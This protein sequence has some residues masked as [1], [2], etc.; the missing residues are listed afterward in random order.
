MEFR[1]DKILEHIHN[2]TPEAYRFIDEWLD[3]SPYIT[4]HTSGSTGKPKAIRLFKADMVTSAI[5]T[6][7]FFNITD[8]SSM[9]CPLSANY[10]A[11]KMMIVRAMLS[12]AN[13]WIEKPG[14]TPV[15]QDYGN[16]DL[17]AVVPSQVQ[18]LLN[19]PDIFKRL[20]H[21]LIGGAAVPREL[22]NRITAL[23]VNAYVSYGMTET[24]SHVAL[25]RIGKSSDEIYEAMS[26]ICFSTD[27]RGCLIVKSEKR[28]FHSLT[29]ND[30][31][32]LIDDKHF[33]WVGRFDNVI[34]SGGIKV[35]PE[36]IEK[37][38]QCLIPEDM[39]YY[40]SKC[41]DDKWGEVPVLVLSKNVENAK[42][43]LEDIRNIVKSKAERPAGIIV[44]NIE[45]TSTGK[46][47]RQQFM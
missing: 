43:M 10:I 5:S 6:N 19:N 7:I 9:L 23:G 29:T 16:I 46:I 13:L 4:A 34:N 17:I 44:R 30:I 27:S 15:C 32:D 11:G 1:R 12:G 41:R 20:K 8:K 3:E 33:I 35:Y 18:H 31:I 37:Q 36:E 21:I 39:E 25:R 2:C 26:D 24:C 47:I 42:K 22:S 28:S 45:Y 38:I 14:N 40:I